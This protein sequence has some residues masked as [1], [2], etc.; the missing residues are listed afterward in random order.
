M[1]V[2][3]LCGQHAVT[4]CGGNVASCDAGPAALPGL[5]LAPEAAL[6][7]RLPAGGACGG[8]GACP[9]TAGRLCRPR[10][11]RGATGRGPLWARQVPAAH[12]WPGTV[13]SPGLQSLHLKGSQHSPVTLR[14]NLPRLA[15]IAHLSLQHATFFLRVVRCVIDSVTWD[16]FRQVP[17]GVHA[18]R[19]ARSRW[20]TCFGRWRARGTALASRRTACRCPRWSRCFCPWSANTSRADAEAAAECSC[21]TA[22]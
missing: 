6:R 16:V 20:R 13:P 22:C 21:G 11:G 14:M 10:A 17:E 9:G 18:G 19:C 4:Q 8:R 5:Q 12:A 1:S 3:A 2:D 7:G 15:E